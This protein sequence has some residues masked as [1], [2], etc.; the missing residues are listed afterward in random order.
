MAPEEIIKEESAIKDY[1]K[2]L[3]KKN[4]NLNQDG[5]VIPVIHLDDAGN[6]ADDSFDSYPPELFNSV[7]YH[8]KLEL[9]LFLLLL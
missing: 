7:Q 6:D 4:N 1:N 9:L 8:I 3:K 2:K 5:N